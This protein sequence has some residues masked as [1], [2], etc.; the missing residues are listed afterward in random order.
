MGM[1][2]L[3]TRERWHA[4]LTLWILYIIGIVAFGLVDVRTGLID[5]WSFT[6]LWQMAAVF[7]T[8]VG[9]TI[10]VHR[11]RSNTH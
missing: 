2:G 11:Q 4:T 1:L 7:I 6:N 10:A 3:S 5:L 9:A 8:L